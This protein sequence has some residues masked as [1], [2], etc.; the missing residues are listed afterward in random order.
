[1]RLQLLY[2]AGLTLIVSACNAAG[3]NPGTPSTAPGAVGGAGLSDGVQPAV[4]TTSVLKLLT[5]QEVIGSTVDPKNGDQNPYGLV[6][7]SANPFGRSPLKKGDLVVC[8]FN[9]KNNVQGNGTTMEYMASTPGSTPTNFL[10]SSTIKG[11]ASLVINNFGS[12]FTADSAKKNVSEWSPKPANLYTF[13]NHAIVTPWGTAYAPLGLGYPP[14][15]GVFVGDA[16]TGGITRINL[17]GIGSQ[18][19]I[20]AGVIRGFPVN[21]GKP[22]TA[23]GPSGMQY[24]KKGDI[25]YVVDGQNNTLYAFSHAYRDL[26]LP[27]EI[28]IGKDGKT[29]TGPKAKD[30]R[31]VYSGSPL[32]GPISSA[33]L[34]NGNLV[35]GNTLDGSGTNLMVEIDTA[36]QVL[37]TKN[38][39]QGPGGAIF[40]MVA[41][42][43]NDANTQIFFNDDN[44][45]NVQHLTH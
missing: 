37:A 41:I 24:A 40:G 3:T 43:S 10:Q 30:A 17:N 13:T 32:N 38:V 19:S 28:M 18:P 25:L 27:K 6:Y 33:L 7:V 23:L 31:V 9:D 44:A 22:G 35:I 14:G 21:R 20:V 11:C 15:D 12:T 42:G 34:P 16:F 5:K 2:A 8:N 1:M 29:F 39:D 4:D 45:N 26:N 36:G